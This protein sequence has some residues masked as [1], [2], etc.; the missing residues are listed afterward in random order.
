V[1]DNRIPGFRVLTFV[2]V[3]IISSVSYHIFQTYGVS[4]AVAVATP[5]MAS[6]KDAA[7]LAPPRRLTKEELVKTHSTHLK[8][9]DSSPNA[10]RPVKQPIM[11]EAYPASTK[12]IRELE[13]VSFSKNPSFSGQSWLTLFF[14]SH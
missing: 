14:R 6:I 13:I 4:M 11:S 2:Q 9:Q 10:P 1:A 5:S 7:G 3:L 12:P 8:K